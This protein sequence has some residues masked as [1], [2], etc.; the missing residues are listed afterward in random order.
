[1]TNPSK[2]HLSIV[3]YCFQ[4]IF[5]IMKEKKHGKA[6]FT[7][8]ELERIRVNQETIEKISLDM[9]DVS[10]DFMKI[11]SSSTPSHSKPKTHDKERRRKS[12]R[13][14]LK[15]H[16]RLSKDIAGI[17]KVDSGGSNEMG[18]MSFMHYNTN[19]RLDR[20]EQVQP[21]FDMK[22][23]GSGLD[24]TIACI[25]DE[26]AEEDTSSV[27]EFRAQIDSE[28][29]SKGL[30]EIYKEFNDICVL[31]FTRSLASVL[32]DY[33]KNKTKFT[34]K[35]CRSR[36]EPGL[37]RQPTQDCVNRILSESINMGSPYLRETDVGQPRGRETQLNYDMSQ[38]YLQDYQKKE[39]ISKK[40]KLMWI[41][42][43]FW[44]FL[45]SAIMILILFIVLFYCNVFST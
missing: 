13:K 37:Q 2:D 39:S 42:T 9:L 15:K 38:K 35:F 22:L 30:K 5:K 4:E 8:D 12:V 23:T 25:S 19:F 11:F 41:E 1:M 34:R 26:E 29:I 21:F 36:K 40:G 14:S 6:N 31:L 16:R 18:E 24:T 33:S 17:Y 28:V 10:V 32:K 45:V 7:S 3:K 43:I 44:V 20:N 27:E